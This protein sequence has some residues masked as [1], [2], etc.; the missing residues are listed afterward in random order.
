MMYRFATRPL[1]DFVDEVPDL[2]DVAGD[3]G[4]LFVR[5]GT[6]FAGVATVARV[7][8]SECADFFAQSTIDDRVDAPGSR[9]VA[10]GWYPFGGVGGEAIIPAICVGKHSSLPPWVTYVEGNE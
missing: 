7:S 2:N 6:G 4:V 9:G 10:F 1:S 8:L 3:D 5:D